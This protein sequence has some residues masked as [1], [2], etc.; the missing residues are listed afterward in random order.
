MRVSA[1]SVKEEKRGTPPS[2]SFSHGPRTLCSQSSQDNQ[3]TMK[4]HSSRQ[5]TEISTSPMS[6]KKEGGWPANQ[7]FRLH[8]SVKKS[9]L[10][11]FNFP[12]R[13]ANRFKDM[14]SLR[15]MKGTT[16]EDVDALSKRAR[17]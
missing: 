11:S 10:S 15:L 16:W 12:G 9:T 6:N 7:L 5:R 3:V 17:K 1:R 14:N 2:C 13:E 4:V 8:C